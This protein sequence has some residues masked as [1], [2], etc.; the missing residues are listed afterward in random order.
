MLGPTLALDTVRTIFVHMCW[1]QLF[2]PRYVQVDVCWH[3]LG[4]ILALDTFRTMSADICWVQLFFLNVG[5]LVFLPVYWCH[6]CCCI[7]VVSRCQNP[8]SYEIFQ[9]PS[10]PIPQQLYVVNWYFVVFL[11]TSTSSWKRI[12]SQPAATI[13]HRPQCYIEQNDRAKRLSRNQPGSKKTWQI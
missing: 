7:Q 6:I 4:P 10:S 5:N 13:Y 11:C 3:V 9:S 2:F 12:A 1:V 8:G